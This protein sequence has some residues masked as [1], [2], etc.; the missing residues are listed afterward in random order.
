MTYAAE[1]Q[2]LDD[3]VLAAI[4]AWRDRGIGLDDA[5]FDALALDIF[6]HQLRYN[7]PYARYCA[8]FGVSERSLPDTWSAIPAVP[9]AAYKEADLCTF[10][11]QRAEL[12]FETSGTT[13][14]VGG[15]HF[16]ETRALYDAALLAG[17]ERSML[18]SA[19]GRLRYLLLVPNPEL[20]PHSSLGYM[21]RA[22]S[23]AFGVGPARWYLDEEKLD[24]ARFFEDAAAAAGDGVA[25]CVA[26]TAFAFAEILASAR[27]RGLSSVPL[28]RG[29][30][31]M[32]TG[33]FK[34]RARVIA[35]EDLYRELA[36]LFALPAARIVAEYGMTE[37]TSQYYDDVAAVAPD[38]ALRAR[39]KVAPPWMR[40]L[41]VDAGGR[42]LPDGVVGSLVH[43]D[44]ANRSSCVAVA[45]E[46]LG[47]RFPGGIALVGRDQGA[48]LRGCSLDVEALERVRA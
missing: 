35:R 19:S 37:L 43:V 36:A 8:A 28:P 29:S 39:L 27:E 1:A 23:G 46:D 42:A 24:A 44:L 20:R 34:G 30:L 45:T 22:V 38:N 17:F 40:A 25:L 7:T 13:R 10:D 41:V 26:G 16:M 31:V 32:E 9:A 12:V 18:A 6:A 21:M 3:T 47:A 5:A 4:A 33:G 15:K 48:E 2:R 11:P 14:G